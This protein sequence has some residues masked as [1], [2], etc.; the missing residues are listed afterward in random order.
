MS[1]IIKANEIQNSSGGADVKI[2]ALKHPSSSSNNLVLASDGS[3]TI[4]SASQLAILNSQ[5]RFREFNQFRY[6]DE[7]QTSSN[8]TILNVSGNEYVQVTPDSTSDILEFNFAHN[9]YMSGGYFGHVF[10]RATNTAFN[11]GLSYFYV[12]G[13]HSEGSFSYQS[14]DG[15]D[16]TYSSGTIWFTCTGLSAGT[17]YYFRKGVKTH[18]STGTLT[19]GPAS[20]NGVLSRGVYFSVKRWSTA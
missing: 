19:V 10:M 14:N 20:T 12:S 18:S 5:G 7:S 3:V 1:S 8:N 9:T 15:G 16:Y 17:T 2:Q 11:T 13:E 4:A 6:D